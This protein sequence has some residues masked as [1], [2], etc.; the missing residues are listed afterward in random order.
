MANQVFEEHFTGKYD[1]VIPALLLP[2]GSLSGGANVRKVS[3]GGGWKVRKGST[4]WNT[5]ALGDPDAI[6]SLHYYKNPKKEDAHFIGQYDSKLYDLEAL[7]TGGYSGVTSLGVTVGTTPG[8]SDVVGENWFYA[9]GSGR[10]ITWGGDEP[11]CSGFVVYDSSATAYIDYTR[12]VT[13]GRTSTLALLG[14]GVSDTY[15]VC[16]GEI[17]SGIIPDIVQGVVGITVIPHF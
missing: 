3:P 1:G 16:S 10:P 6:N 12:K 8:F 4:L 9:D 15:F 2:K 5:A 11:L 13:D 14:T 7:P 17:A